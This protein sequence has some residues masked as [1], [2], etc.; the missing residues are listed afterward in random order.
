[1]MRYLKAAWSAFFDAE[2]RTFTL[3]FLRD[4]WKAGLLVLGL[5]FIAFMFDF[6]RIPAEEAAVLKKVDFFATVAAFR[7]WLHFHF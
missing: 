2:T 6:S 7:D 3:S 5:R 1:M 4:L